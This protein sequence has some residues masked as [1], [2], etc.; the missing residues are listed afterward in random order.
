[1]KVGI[2]SKF[3]STH[4]SR[5]KVATDTETGKSYAM[6]LMFVEDAEDQEDFDLSLFLTLMNNEVERLEKLPIHNNIISLIEY[7]WKGVYTTSK[8]VEKEVLYCVLDLATGG[9]L[10]DY[11]FTV[12]RGLP[13]DIARYYFHKLIDA[14]QL[15]HE[16]NVVHRD[17][18]LENLLLDSEYNLKIA[19]FGLST[20]VESSYGGGVMHTRVGTER[21]MP[22]EMLEKNA[23]VGIC[24]D[25]FAAGIILFVLVV[26]I[27]PTHK[28]AESNDYLYKY[29]RKKEYEKYWTV[30]SKLLNLDLSGISEDFFHLVTTMVKYD[31]KKRFTIEEIKAHAWMQGPIATEEEVKKELA[32]RKIEIKRKLG[33]SDD[34]DLEDL[35]DVH[36]DEFEKIERGDEPEWVEEEI[37]R[38]IKVYNPEF[39]AMTECFSTF[40]PNVLLGAVYNFCKDKILEFKLGSEDYSATVQMPSEDDNIVDF[41]V[42][43]LKVKPELD[44][45][46][47]CDEL[48]EVEDDDD[49]K[50]CVVFRK[51]RGPKQDFIKIF[52]SFRFFFKKLNNIE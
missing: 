6:K 8:G 7:D 52:R 48:E 1:M 35:A 45:E 2:H 12:G 42:E 46:V 36:K 23:Y 17:L 27:M 3:Y 51:K 20:T 29:I 10:F 38:R 30:I 21:Y 43:V 16:S 37:D 19:D 26:G 5:V 50:Y 13:E 18:K 44:E 11:I 14:I 34:T 24:A 31:Y 9:D 39:P 33:D 15:L 41:A 47:D 32:S 40:K 49:I 28:T 22:P 4:L 25:L